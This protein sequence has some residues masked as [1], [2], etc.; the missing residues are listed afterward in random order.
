VVN[1]TVEKEVSMEKGTKATVLVVVLGVFFSIAATSY[2]PDGDHLPV[3]SIVRM[4]QS[5]TEEIRKAIFVNDTLTAYRLGKSCEFEAVGRVVVI[6]V[7]KSYFV[8]GKI[9]SGEIRTNDVVKKGPMAFI[10]FAQ[11]DKCA[12]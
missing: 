1:K 3:G 5:G 6:S 7:G 2:S 12:K 8:S 11:D 10:I 4:F 9:V